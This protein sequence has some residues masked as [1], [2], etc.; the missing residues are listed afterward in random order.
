M[1]GAR[2]AVPLVEAEHPATVTSPSD[3]NAAAAD[4]ACRPIEHLR[5][6]RRE[7]TLRSLPVE[8]VGRGAAGVL[9]SESTPRLG[10]PAAVLAEAVTVRPPADTRRSTSGGTSSHRRRRT[11][12]T[13]ARRRPCASTPAWRARCSATS[14]RRALRPPR[15]ITARRRT[16]PPTASASGLSS[17]CRPTSRIIDAGDRRERPRLGAG[18][19]DPA[20]LLVGAATRS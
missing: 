16:S 2:P 6:C 3:S 9:V 4:P 18:A 8:Q 15:A 13:R 7:P 19:S 5:V 1:G 17:R 11:T 10:G 14:R 20:G 12:T